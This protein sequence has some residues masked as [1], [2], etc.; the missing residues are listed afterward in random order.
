MAPNTTGIKVLD[1]NSSHELCTHALDIAQTILKPNG[2]LVMVG[3]A[4]RKGGR[5]KERGGAVTT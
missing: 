5:E 1:A 2:T 4:E 3:R